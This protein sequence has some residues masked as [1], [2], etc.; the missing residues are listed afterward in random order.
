MPGFPSISTDVMRWL[1]LLV[2]T[3]LISVGFFMMT[4]GLLIPLALAAIVGAIFRPFNAWLIRMLGGR[5]ALSSAI[6]LLILAGVVFIPLL[7]L[8][9]LAVSQAAAMLDGLEALASRVETTELDRAL[10]QW[11]PFEGTLQDV[12]D[13]ALDSI[14]TIAREGARFFVTS[15]SAVT[16]GAATFFLHFFVFLYALFFFLQMDTPVIV[17]MLR[18]SG[19]RQSTQVLLNER[20]VS[21]SRATIKGTFMIALIQGSMGGVSFALAG[22]D[23]VAFWAVVMMVLAMLPGFGAPFGVV[24]GAVYLGINDQYVTAIA[25]LAWAGV[26]SV[27]DNLLRPTLVGRDAQLH[28]LIILISTLGGLG[29]FG[30]SGL[31]LGPVLAGLFVAIW[32]TLAETM[33][34]PDVTDDEPQNA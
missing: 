25:M 24:C 20:I 21:V 34:K 29:M 9:T 22:I 30:A 14:G 13:K 23:G 27:I 6:C 10:P 11:L 19:L 5:V 15:V 16:I 8:L 28:D 2:A 3:L 31:V 26:I 4:S 18:F 33:N 7:G 32:R 17:Q 12:Y 1:A